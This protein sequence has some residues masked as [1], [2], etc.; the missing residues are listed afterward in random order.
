MSALPMPW[1]FLRLN[2][3]KT[4]ELEQNFGCTTCW[5]ESADAAWS[6]RDALSKSNLVD[7]SHYSVKLLSCPTC[8]QSFLSVF[9]EQIDWADGEDPQYWTTIPVTT[10]EAAMLRGAT[11]SESTINST[12]SGRRS[13]VRDFPKGSDPVAGWGYGIRVG[14]HD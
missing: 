9:T 7:E 8:S 10:A 1:F 6:A 4:T 5:P 2:Q 14:M 3:M 11:P 12:G 13:L